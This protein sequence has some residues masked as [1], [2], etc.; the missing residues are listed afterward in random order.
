M[1]LSQFFPDLKLGYLYTYWGPLVRIIFIR[2]H[3][4]QLVYGMYCTCNALQYAVRVSHLYDHHHPPPP[5]SSALIFC[6]HKVSKTNVGAI[7]QKNLIC[8]HCS[9]A[10]LLV[11]KLRYQVTIIFSRFSCWL[12]PCFEKP[13]MIFVAIN[14]T[15]RSIVRSIWRYSSHEIW[16]S[17][18][19]LFLRPNWKLEIW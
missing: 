16:P 9:C 10:K 2:V 6:A 1:A 13:S 17:V 15:K 14:V 8:H 11:Y 18:R 4:W 3:W 7:L 12:S 19:S 5:K